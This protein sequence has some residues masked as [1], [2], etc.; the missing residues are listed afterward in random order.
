MKI[1]LPVAVKFLPKRNK[2]L[3]KNLASYLSL[4]A[5]DYA[6]LLSPHVQPIL[7]SIGAG[8]YGLCRA[9][10][11]IYEV[12]PDE[13]NPHAELLVSLLPLCDLQ[14][15]L[16]LLQLFALMAHNKPAVRIQNLRKLSN[17]DLTIHILYRFWKQA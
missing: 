5:I 3:S 16:A 7:D 14:E 8:N 6:Y 10:P 1:A 9:L 4:A 15:R 13:L 11:Q 12:S 2:E 17:F